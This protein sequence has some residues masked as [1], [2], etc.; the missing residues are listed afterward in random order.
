M[1]QG[2]Y[3]EVLSAP[4]SWQL[5][6]GSVL[7]RTGN[8]G[9]LL[10]AL[11]AGE[12]RFG[13]YAQAG[14]LITCLLV[15]SSVGAPVRGRW[16][17]QRGLPW[18]LGRSLTFT[19]ISAV[20]MLYGFLVE[21]F[22]LGCVGAF[23]VG[24]VSAAAQPLLPVWCRALPARLRVAAASLESATSSVCYSVTPALGGVMLF[25]VDP[26]VMLIVSVVLTLL[27]LLLMA[28]SPAA[29]HDPDAPAGGGRR[30][31]GSREPLGFAV[32]AL[33]AATVFQFAMLDVLIVGNAVRA[34]EAGA[35]GLV[36]VLTG[37]LIAGSTLGAYAIRQRDSI[38]RRLNVGANALVGLC[39]LLTVLTFPLLA[40]LLIFAALGAARGVQGV[41]CGVLLAEIGDGPR[42][43]EI[44]SWRAVAVTVGAAIGHTVGGIAVTHIGLATSGLLAGVFGISSTIMLVVAYRARSSAPK[45][46]AMPEALPA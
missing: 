44:F 41:G 30:V 11:I 22:W 17:D 34:E 6:S 16:A 32:F 8:A 3:G 36:G 19:A 18:M 23:L 28:T 39:A 27:G 42:M 21:S 25:V 1:R 10:F 24:V 12:E 33:L 9:F 5:F 13:T 31:P 46:S 45:R 4:G 26:L 29:R 35:Q 2:R 20:I 37:V 38:S 40:T 15:G 14:I 43:M 7:G